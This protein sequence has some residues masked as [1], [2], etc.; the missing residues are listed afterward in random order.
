MRIL[1]SPIVK[2]WPIS[3]DFTNPQLVHLYAYSFPGDTWRTVAIPLK[4]FNFKHLKRSITAENATDSPEILSRVFI[5]TEYH[6]DD[7][8]AAKG[9]HFEVYWKYL[10]TFGV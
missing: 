1:D 3:V 10:D 5:H 6:F 4:F 9:A 7:C 2:L 8:R